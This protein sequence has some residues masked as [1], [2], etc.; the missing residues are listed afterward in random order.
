M[1]WWYIYWYYIPLLG[2]S[3][4][5]L[6]IKLWHYAYVL[7]EIWPLFKIYNTSASIFLQGFFLAFGWKNLYQL[8]LDCN[9]TRTNNHLVRKRTLN[10]LAKLD[11]SAK[12]WLWVRVSLQSLKIMSM[13]S[14]SACKTDKSFKERNIFV[15]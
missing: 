8:A 6:W 9:G 15:T 1:E 10:N 12:K 11:S 7:L 3:S 14:V 5:K 2:S 4:G 13:S